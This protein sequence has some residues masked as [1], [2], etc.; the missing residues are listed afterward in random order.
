MQGL[1]L[2]YTCL[3]WDADMRYENGGWHYYRFNGNTK[4]N[5]ITGATENQQEQMKYMLN[6]YR[7]LLTRARAGMVICIPKRRP[8]IF[9]STFSCFW[10]L[11]VPFRLLFCPYSPLFPYAPPLV[12]VR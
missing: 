4:R 6:A 10:V 8:N 3:L 1:E 2:D 7:V 5:E 12:R 9:I 11:F